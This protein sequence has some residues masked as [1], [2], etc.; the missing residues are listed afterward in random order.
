MNVNVH[1]NKSVPHFFLPLPPPPLPPPLQIKLGEPIAVNCSGI[2][3]H[4]FT[5]KF[6]KMAQNG[7]TE[8][9][10]SCYKEMVQRITIS[11]SIKRI[12]CPETIFVCLNAFPQFSSYRAETLQVG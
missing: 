5:I 11:I 4:N 10:L 8:L 1:W 6:F 12:V 2:M 7:T 3:N 9:R